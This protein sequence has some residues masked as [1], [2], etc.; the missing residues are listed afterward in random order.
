M[1]HVGLVFD[2]RP[3]EGFFGAVDIDR[4]AVLAGGVEQRADDARGEIGVLEFYVAVS[5]A[6]GD[7]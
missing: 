1:Q 6:K 7:Q 4:F 2:E 3:L 5:T